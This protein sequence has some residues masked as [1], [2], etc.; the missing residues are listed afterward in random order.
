MIYHSG[1]ISR[2]EREW[3]RPLLLTEKYQRA[4]VET[5]ISFGDM[6]GLS[7]KGLFKSNTK[8][9][10]ENNRFKFKLLRHSDNFSSSFL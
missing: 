6:D 1:V 2:K 5:Q 4:G 10:T 7:L 3:L 8:D 9:S